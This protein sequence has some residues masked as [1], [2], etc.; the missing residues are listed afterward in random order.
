MHQSFMPPTAI[1]SLN[2]AHMSSIV[3]SVVPR[4]TIEEIVYITMD[5]DQ[6]FPQ[7]VTGTA[8]PWKEI[9][10]ALSFQF[11]NIL[12]G[13]SFICDEFSTAFQNIRSLRRLGHMCVSHA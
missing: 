2:T 1:A 5:L 11:G 9:G 13:W 10:M 12:I 3:C 8:S 6:L 7:P 4:P